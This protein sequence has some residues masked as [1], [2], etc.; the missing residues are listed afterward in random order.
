MHLMFGKNSIVYF[1]QRA[2]DMYTML[3][4]KTFEAMHKSIQTFERIL[5]TISFSHF[6]FKLTHPIAEI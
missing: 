3:F 1:F 6:K 5:I 2:D 4:K